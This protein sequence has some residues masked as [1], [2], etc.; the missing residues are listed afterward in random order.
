MNKKYVQE[1]KKFLDLSF[2]DGVI[3]V[4][5][6]RSVKEF[7]EEGTELGHCIFTNKYFDLK[8]SL[9]LSAK[10]DK[11]RIETVELSLSKMEVVQARGL[12]NKPTKYHE[13]IVKLVN[14]NI[15]AITKKVKLKMTGP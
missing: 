6:L 13:Q 3:H 8:H 14:D 11:T 5:P 7:L 9:L 4:E 12:G 1:K 15:P 10:I 2:N